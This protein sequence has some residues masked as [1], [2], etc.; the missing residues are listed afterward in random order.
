MKDKIKCPKCG[1][2]MRAVAPEKPYKY[3]A[4]GLD[5]VILKG[6]EAYECACGDGIIALPQI[7][8]LHQTL[9]ITILK[10]PALLNGKE[11]RFLRKHFRLKAVELADKLNVSKVTVSRWEN[12]EEPIGQAN[13]RLVR[14]FFILTFVDELN[15]AHVFAEVGKRI[16]NEKSLSEIQKVFDL[17]IEKRKRFPINIKEKNLRLQLDPFQLEEA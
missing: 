5:N 10:K 8:Q 12:E 14:I 6:F 1:K 17:P 16:L 7:G 13:D 2:E 4:S 3:T 15:K 9:A 11:L